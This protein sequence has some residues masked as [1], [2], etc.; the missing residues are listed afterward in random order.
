MTPLIFDVLLRFRVNPIALVGDIEKAFLNIEIH[1]EHRDC[2]RFLW[3]NDIHAESPEIVTYRF[4][5]VVFGCNSSP[6]LL[7]CVLRHHISRFDEEVPEFVAKM[8]GG[9]FVDDLVTGCND[10]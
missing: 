10:T 9:F 1:P 8:I 3:L 5:R 4:N 7:N 6:L 2:L